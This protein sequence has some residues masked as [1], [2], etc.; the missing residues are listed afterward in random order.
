MDDR[1]IIRD[2]IDGDKEKY[3][4]LVEKYQ[5]RLV[6]FIFA[7]VYDYD[8]ANDIAQLSFIKAY[9]SLQNYNPKY[10]F[11]TWL[12]TIANNLIK[13]EMKKRKNISLEETK[14]QI[15]SKQ[16]PAE[17]VAK[18]QQAQVIRSAITRL[19]KR[20][21]MVINLYYW[22]E[23]SYREISDIMR[24]NINT[25]RT[26]ISRAKKELKQQLNGQI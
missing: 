20:Y 10:E 11:S 26:W 7:Q 13:S 18:E 14:V 1:T 5:Q 2:I 22:Q 9:S 19:S 4:E 24:V 25:I 15:H 3:R 21:Q 12:Y 16:N 23:L 6:N 8:L 17:D